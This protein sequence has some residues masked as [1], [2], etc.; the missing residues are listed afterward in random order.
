MSHVAGSALVCFRS[1]PSLFRLLFPQAS[2]MPLLNTE[3]VNATLFLLCGLGAGCL[4]HP[5]LSLPGHSPPRPSLGSSFYSLFP[6]LCFPILLHL[7]LLL[8]P[9]S[10]TC[11]CSPLF[12][13]VPLSPPHSVCS[14]CPAP[15]MGE[16][17]RCCSFASEPGP[18]SHSLLVGW[19]S[20]GLGMAGAKWAVSLA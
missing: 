6:L 8:E 9:P 11:V 15:S 14:V 20:G 1:V 7:C 13:V 2:D 10:S 3:G 12:P 5:L 17:A 19:R 4:S 18:A 16:E